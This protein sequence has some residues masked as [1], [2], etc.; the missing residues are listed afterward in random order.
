MREKEKKIKKK[1][2]RKKKEE[3]RPRFPRRVSFV[4]LLLR[5]RCIDVQTAQRA[6]L[7]EKIRESWEREEDGS[8][9]GEGGVEGEGGGGRR[10]RS[11]WRAMARSNAHNAR[12]N[13]NATASVENTSGNS[14][15]T[16]VPPRAHVLPDQHCFP[17]PPSPPPRI[18]FHRIPLREIEVTI[19]NFPSLS[20]S[21]YIT[22]ENRKENFRRGINNIII[23]R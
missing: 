11:T 23:N 22:N 12:I 14:E 16:D 17:L 1:K 19:M 7:G 13:R 5:A 10:R 4:L 9:R 3:A 6:N 2:K 21:L 15:L 8:G 18:V 20:L